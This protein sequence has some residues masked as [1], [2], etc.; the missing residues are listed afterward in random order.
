MA[1]EQIFDIAIGIIFLVW[2]IIFWGV[3]I[4]SH[5]R[6][7]KSFDRLIEL[8]NEQYKEMER[9]FSKKD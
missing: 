6:T 5:R 7:M 9:N 3:M 4:S 2:S 8:N 1:L